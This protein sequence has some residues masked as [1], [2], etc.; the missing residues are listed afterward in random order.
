MDGVYSVAPC[1]TSGVDPYTRCSG[2][3]QSRALAAGLTTA[4]AAGFLSTNGYECICCFYNQCG[5]KPSS[6]R[7]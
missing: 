6:Q 4:D 1:T 2:C 3:C 7:W 5:Y